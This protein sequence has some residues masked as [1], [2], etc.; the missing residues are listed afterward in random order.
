MSPHDDQISRPLLGMGD[1]QVRRR[2]ADGLKQH[3]LRLQALLPDISLGLFDDLLA[4][5]TKRVD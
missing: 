1:D 2:T 3:A 4:P 5:L